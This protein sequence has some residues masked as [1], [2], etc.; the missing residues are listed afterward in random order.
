MSKKED[1]TLAERIAL[2]VAFVT[3][4]VIALVLYQIGFTGWLLSLACHFYQ[5]FC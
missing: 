3:L 5:L 4:I 2:A 1:L